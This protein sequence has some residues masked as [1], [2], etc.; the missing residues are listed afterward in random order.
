MGLGGH[1]LAHMRN[2]VRGRAFRLHS[3]GER[4]HM[5]SR[6]YVMG[7]GAKLIEVNERL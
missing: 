6:H 3:V 1:S 5:A 4:P 7:R 2:K